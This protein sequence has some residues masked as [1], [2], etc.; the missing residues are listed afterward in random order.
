MTSTT[1]QLKQQLRRQLRSRRR[2]LTAHQQRFAAQRLTQQVVRSPGYSRMR[3]VALYW[4]TDGEI[5]VYPLMRRLLR[6]GKGVYLPVLQP[7]KIALWFR[8]WHPGSTMK[9]N[10]FGIPEP[11]SG[12]RILPWAMD[13]V[14]LPLVGFDDQGGR[15]GMG[16]GFYDRTFAARVRWP[17]QPRLIGV[18]HQCQ[19]VERIPLESWDIPLAAVVTDQQ[20][21]R[22]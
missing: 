3:S 6:D 4:A 13:W 16:G 15:L 21:W 20:Q 14:L 2:A 22:L 18:A 19:Q 17:R 10:R 7:R 5:D 8:P 1:A 11:T 9:A 12:R